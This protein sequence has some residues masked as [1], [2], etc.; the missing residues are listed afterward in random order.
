MFVWVESQPTPII[1]LM[2]FAL[3][4]LLEGIILVV[5]RAVRSAASRSPTPWRKLTPSVPRWW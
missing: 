4:Y 1:S 5:T 2:M 3:C